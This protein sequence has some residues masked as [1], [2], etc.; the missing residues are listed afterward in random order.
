MLTMTTLDGS[1]SVASDGK[2]LTYLWKVAPGGKTAAILN[3]NTA[4]PQVQFGEGYG[5]YNFTLTVTDSTGAQATDTT[6]ILYVGR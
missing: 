2:P 1:T 5:Y 4:N 3:A 6:S